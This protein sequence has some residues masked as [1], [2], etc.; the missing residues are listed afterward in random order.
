MQGASFLPVG[1]GMPT[2]QPRRISRFAAERLHHL[3]GCERRGRARR[4]TNAELAA[5]AFRE[6]DMHPSTNH[7][8]RP[9]R[10]SRPRARAARRRPRG[11]PRRRS[12]PA[13]KNRLASNYR[14]N[15]HHQP[16]RAARF[17][18]PGIPTR[19]GT[20][21][22]RREGDKMLT[23]IDVNQTRVQKRDKQEFKEE[24]PLTIIADG[25]LAR[26]LTEGRRSKVRREDEVRCREPVPA[27]YRGPA[28]GPHQGQ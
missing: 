4:R 1:N 22:W 17:W 26:V 13:G 11:R 3:P 28:E 19:P 15:D 20:A 16:Y 2:S 7:A 24:Q 18:Q 5:S 23:R 25:A 21:E 10:R 14:E 12:S 6:S 8:G 27:G 9:G